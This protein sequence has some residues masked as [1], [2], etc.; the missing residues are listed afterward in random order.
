MPSKNII[1][2]ITCSKNKNKTVWKIIHRT[3]NTKPDVCNVTS[4]DGKGNLVN[5]GHQI[6]EALNKHFVSI[7]QEMVKTSLK[8]NNTP[9]NANPLHYL[10]QL[11]NHPLPPLNIKYASTSE[12]ENTV[13]SLKKKILVDMME[14]QQRY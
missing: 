9:N 5:N 2:L 12:V 3:I 13:R 4:I 11:R 7:A 14:Y 1:I 8:G 10:I 6:A